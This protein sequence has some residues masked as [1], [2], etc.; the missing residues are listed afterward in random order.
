MTTSETQTTSSFI[1]A[2]TIC[3]FYNEKEV[4]KMKEFINKRIADYVAVYNHTDVAYYNWDKI[5]KLVKAVDFVLCAI[6]ERT[7]DCFGEI[8]NLMD[9]AWRQRKIKIGKG[10]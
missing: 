8:Y 6:L 10:R 1:F 7:T 5:P 4:V 2:R 3:N 9:D